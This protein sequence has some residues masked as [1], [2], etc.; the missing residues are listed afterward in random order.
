MTPDRKHYLKGVALVLGATLCWSSGGLLVRQIQI[1]DAWGVIGYRSLWVTFWILVAL[2]VSHRGRTVRAFRAVGWSGIVGGICLSLAFTGFIMSL[3]STTVANTLFVMSASPFFGAILG[4][5]VLREPVQPTTWAAIAVA[6][7]GI[8]VMVSEGLL[9]TAGS[10]VLFGSVM[11]LLAA[12]GMGGYATALRRGRAVDMTPSICI[13][14]A[15]TTVVGI[16]LT[17]TPLIGWH[18]LAVTFVLG[19]VQIGAGVFLFVRGSRYLP[20][21]ELTLLAL[22]ET[23]L[24]SFWVWLFLGESPSLWTLAGGAIVLGAVVAQPFLAL[25]RSRPLPAAAD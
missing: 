21:A 3:L 12:L 25:L 16:G 17:G 23:L 8:G 19:L 14:G 5:L 7:G 6:L 4:R 13:A 10:G 2:A 24:G 22:M 15:L 20:A 9:A 11:A 1:A 18:D